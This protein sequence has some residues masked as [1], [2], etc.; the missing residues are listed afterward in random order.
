MLNATR[1]NGQMRIDAGL[2]GV[3]EGL[4]ELEGFYEMRPVSL[5]SYEG[6]HYSRIS[7]QPIPETNLSPRVSQS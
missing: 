7:G 2:T 1:V 6:R 5:A 3:E 4:K